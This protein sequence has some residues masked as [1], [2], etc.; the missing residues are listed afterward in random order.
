MK[1]EEKGKNIYFAS[2]VHLGAPSIKNHREHE[3]N[4]VSWLDS[5]KPTTAQLYLMGDIFD[6]WFEYHHVVPRGFTRFLGKIAEF[7]DAG[8]PVHFFTGN[9]D[10]WVFN[11]LPSEIGVQVHRKPFTVDLNGK[12]FY[13]A[14][15]D[16]LGPYD[17]SYN[18]LKKIFTNK[19]LQWFFARLHPN[20]AIAFARRWSA[21]SRLKNESAE[22]SKF[23][24]EDKEWLMLYAKDILKKE[25]FDYFVFGHRHIDLH[26]PIGQNSEFVYLGDWVNYYSYGVWDGQRFELKYYHKK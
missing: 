26:Q 17:K 21:H 3:K 5:I 23:L 8:I 2:D 22:E 24:G 18:R 1:L 4:F 6:F 19:T 20:F 7:T 13:L 14:H 16:G 15:G 10:I 9:H 11:Y 25:H 12:K